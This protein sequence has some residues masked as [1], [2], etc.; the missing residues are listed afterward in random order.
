MFSVLFLCKLL[1]LYSKDV[2]PKEIFFL[3]VV[4]SSVFYIVWQDNLFN[5]TRERKHFNK[6]GMIF[7]VS[8]INIDNSQH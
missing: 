6:D 3:T 4:N 5:Y 2:N 8:I 7:L 1:L